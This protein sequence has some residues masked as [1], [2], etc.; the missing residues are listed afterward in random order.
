LQDEVHYLDAIHRMSFAAKM[1]RTLRASVTGGACSVVD[2]AGI[3][4][5]SRRTLSRC[6]RAEGATFE[7]LLEDVRYE[8]TCQLLGHTYLLVRD[9]ADALDYAAVAFTRAFRRWSGTTPARWRAT[10]ATARQRPGGA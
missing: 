1:R 7:A 8:V 2:A 6:L 3:Y 9:V 10:S 5:L 4:D